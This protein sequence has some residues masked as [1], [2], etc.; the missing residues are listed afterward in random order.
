VIFKKKG[1]DADS[2]EQI[3]QVLNYCERTFTKKLHYV[4]FSY[5]AQREIDKVSMFV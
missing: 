5:L 2:R 4:L 1:F 3:E